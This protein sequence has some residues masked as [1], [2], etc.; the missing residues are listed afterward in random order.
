M[1]NGNDCTSAGRV[2]SLCDKVFTNGPVTRL[3]NRRGLEPITSNNASDAT[4][5]MPRCGAL[6]FKWIRI[7]FRC[8]KD[9]VSYD[10]DK[11]LAA[12]AKRGSPLSNIIVVATGT[13]C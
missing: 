8:W 9:R 11:Y 6:A 2:R 4:T 3:R 1:V 10:E 12:L 7:V 5:T 13:S